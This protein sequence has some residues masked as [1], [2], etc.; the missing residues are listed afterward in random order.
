[1][2][3]TYWLLTLFGILTGGIGG[4]L[5]KLGSVELQYGNGLPSVVVQAITSP[6]IV[7]AVALYFVPFLIWIYILKKVD[8]SFLQP[9]MAMVYVVTPLLSLLLLK[10]AVPVGRWIGIGIIICGVAVVARS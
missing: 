1:M 5:L 10:E 6:K 3:L 9:I 4:I 8:I 2:P 7:T